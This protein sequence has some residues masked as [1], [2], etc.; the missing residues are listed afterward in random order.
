M[1]VSLIFLSIY[2][3]WGISEITL[4]ITKRSRTKGSKEADKSSLRFLWIAILISTFLGVYLGL[5]GTG[6]ILAEYHFIPTLGILLI[7]LGLILRWTAIL[8]L[9]KYFTVNVAILSNHKV[10]QKG[11]YGFIRHPAYTGSLLSFLGLGI[12]FSNWLSSVVIFLPI[13]VA[14]IYRIKVEE[15]ALVEAFGDEYLNYC[16]VTKR[17]IPKIY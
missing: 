4:A 5:K 15:K 14:F 9:K 3:I 12:S 6:L 17:L 2:L 7:V 13:I 8:T 11:I 16:K 10:I 1:R